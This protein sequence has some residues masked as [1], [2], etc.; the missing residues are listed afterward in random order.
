MKFYLGVKRWITEPFKHRTLFWGFVNQEIKGRYAGSI[1]GLIWSILLPLANL[2]IYIF[3]FTVIFKIRL[4]PENGTD[5]FVLYLLSGLLPW[6]TFSEALGSSP[7][8]FVGKANL[9]TKVAFPIELLPISGVA[10]VFVM[11]SIG[12][13]L[14]LCYL[15]IQGLWNFSW[16]VLPVVMGVHMLFTL[17]LVILIASL[18]V[19]IRDIQQVIGVVLSLWMYL[20]PILY[21]I[22]M[23]PEQIQWILYLNP[24]CMFI[25]LYHQVL[26]CK[27]IP[28]GMLM[29]CFA[30]AMMM[31][32]GGV[33]FFGKSRNAFADVL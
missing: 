12:L 17:G 33:G 30:I 9:I 7:G 13:L 22:T 8:I 29:N 24:M 1:F 15:A 2:L 23:V 11:N 28:W 5:N 27:I 25:E 14:F 31:F 10:V 20:T 16:L 32:I 6:M 4:A 18:S 3:V 21:P 19:F 26:L